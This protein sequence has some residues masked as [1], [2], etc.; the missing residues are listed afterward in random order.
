MDSHNGPP[1]IKMDKGKKEKPKNPGNGKAKETKEKESAK[2]TN[3][4]GKKNMGPKFQKWI[5][6]WWLDP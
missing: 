6:T 3:P 4:T 1:D 2:K 5:F